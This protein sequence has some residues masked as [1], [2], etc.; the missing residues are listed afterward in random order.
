M[1]TAANPPS[2]APV[3][4]P[5]EPGQGN[6]ALKV[7][8]SAEV[9]TPRAAH[10]QLGAAERTERVE[11]SFTAP[12]RARMNE[13]QKARPTERQPDTQARRDEDRE[14]VRNYVRSRPV[15]TIAEEQGARAAAS[16]G[17][18]AEQQRIRSAAAERVRRD[19]T[20]V[21]RATPAELGEL[22]KILRKPGAKDTRE[23]FRRALDEIAS[24]RSE[25]VRTATKQAQPEEAGRIVGVPRERAT[26]HATPKS[27]AFWQGSSAQQEQRW[28]SQMTQDGGRFLH[29]GQLAF[30]D[31]GKSIVGYESS[32]PAVRAMLDLASAKDWQKLRVEGRPE[33]QRAVW[34][35]AQARGIKIE[36]A[37]WKPS[38]EDL[39]P[40]LARGA[41]EPAPAQGTTQGTASRA[42]AKDEPATQREPD[43][44]SR[45][46]RLVASGTAPYQFKEGQR[47]SFYVRTEAD[48]GKQR[49]TWGKDLER[50]LARVDAIAGDRIELVRTGGV[51]VRVR[52]GAGDVNA[53]RGEWT[54]KVLER[55]AREVPQSTTQAVLEKTLR[56]GGYPQRV[57][58]E[59]LK[60][61]RVEET[62]R[63]ARGESFE[64]RAFDPAAART[65]PIPAVVAARGQ[66]EQTRSR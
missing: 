53:Q 34:I 9:E 51:D 15:M 49:V 56:S 46:Y 60:G 29:R 57:I 63:T 35:E 38:R 13:A 23:R 50:A 47:P 20:A 42:P 48:D 58:D 41:A 28:L 14:A 4:P 25:S 16:R 65:T 54:V 21:A 11:P 61:A 55:G 18:S 52:G 40:R 66:P 36:T 1:A 22:A 59:V 33:F 12:V 64:V 43:G 2:A 8:P 44:A 32:T 10:A 17:D 27:P 7:A 24:R 45:G 3:P 37:S 5:S 19:T 39:E 62:R 30:E 6:G 26:E 31:K